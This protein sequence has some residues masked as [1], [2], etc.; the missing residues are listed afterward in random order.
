[1]GGGGGREG[2]AGSK[3]NDQREHEGAFEVLVMFC[4]FLEVLRWVCVLCRNLSSCVLVMCPLYVNKKLKTK[5]RGAG[6]HGILV[7]FGV[8]CLGGLGL[9]GLDPGRRPT[10]LISHAVEVTHI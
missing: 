9:V 10:T 2:E 7:K 3:D 8:L 5:S 4:L 1:M 6:P